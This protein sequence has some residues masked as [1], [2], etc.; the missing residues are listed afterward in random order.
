MPRATAASDSAQLTK[1]ALRRLASFDAGEPA[2]VSLYLDTDGRHRPRRG[3]YE[4]PLKADLL[5]HAD[6][7]PGASRD[8]RASVKGDLQRIHDYVKAFDRSSTR[9]LA[10]FACHAKGLWEV[11][12]LPFPVTDRVVVDRHPH[13]LRLESALSLAETFATVLVN[14]ERARIFTTRLGVC[15]EHI[16]VLD[17]VPGKHDQGG[18]SQARYQRHIEEI[19]HR[20]LHHVV[21]VL[22]R[23]WKRERFDH[24]VLAGPEEVMPMFEKQLQ[25]ELADR[26]VARTSLA[27]N[28]S[29]ERVREATLAVEEVLET[30]RAADA[31]SRVLEEFAGKRHGIVGIERTL[32]AL[33]EGRVEMLIVSDRKPHAG[34]RCSNCRLLAVGD[35]KCPACGAE[36]FVVPDLAEEMVDEALRRRCRVITSMTEPLPEGVGALLRF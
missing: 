16:G 11:Y 15:I 12:R 2:V 30:R 31:V 8:A 6:P 20:H 4:A 14:R 13:V 23:L 18:W 3:D 21:D 17:E 1:D 33:Q 10:F 36:M 34:Y 25:S 26:I 32:L 19:V 22:Y 24:L 5:R 29:K 35:G 28:A 27:I 9:G 7:G